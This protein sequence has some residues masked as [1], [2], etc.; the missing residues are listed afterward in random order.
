MHFALLLPF[1]PL[2]ET[3]AKV[4]ERC[5][6][7]LFLIFATFAGSV[8]VC[9]RYLVVK[10]LLKTDSK[11][12]QLIN[13]ISAFFGLISMASL[14]GVAAFPVSSVFWCHMMAASVH[15]VF[16]MIYLL[17]QSYLSFYLNEV[18]LLV[19]MLRLLL[20][21]AVVLFLF[22]LMILFPISYYRWNA[23]NEFLPAIK[24]P[25]DKGFEIVISTA[26]FEWVMY[27]AY[28]I[29]LMS[30]YLELREFNFVIG[31]VPATPKP[32]E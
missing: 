22:I 30:F 3:G 28:L 19:K 1:I 9:S 2:N 29:Y 17:V 23:E 6:F 14:A 31:L 12:L 7:T 15:F 8:L 10:K 13:M 26:L 16:A 18:P 24:K 25:G 32:A 21:L 11:N 4:P 27:G 5:L 20:C